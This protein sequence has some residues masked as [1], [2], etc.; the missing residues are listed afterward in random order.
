MKIADIITCSICG[1]LAIITLITLKLA[2][3]KKRHEPSLL[4]S[5]Q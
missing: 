1:A 2:L 3:N 5:S 4:S